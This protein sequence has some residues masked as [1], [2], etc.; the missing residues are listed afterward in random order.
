M[1][2]YLKIHEK[3]YELEPAG[4]SLNGNNLL[5]NFKKPDES[6]EETEQTFSENDRIEV[7]TEDGNLVAVYMGYKNVKYIEIFYKI[8]NPAV[9]SVKLEK[10]SRLDALEET[11]DMLTEAILEMGE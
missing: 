11:V 10:N 9:L 4:I 6:I 2:N 8:D 5:L 7:V 3:T 1:K